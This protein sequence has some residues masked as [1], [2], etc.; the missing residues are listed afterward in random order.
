MSNPFIGGIHRVDVAIPVGHQETFVSP[1]TFQNIHHQMFGLIAVRSAEFVVGA[2]HREYASLFDC[3]FEGGQIDFAQ[4][5]LGS[6][7][8][9]RHDD[10]ALEC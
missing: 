5:S 8:H 4:R 9:S 1:L 10:S 6:A 3:C 2:H 7:V